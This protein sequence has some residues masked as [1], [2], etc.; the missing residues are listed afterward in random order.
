MRIVSISDTHNHHPSLQIPEGDVLVH[1][2]DATSRGTVQEIADFLAW[3]AGQPH[4]RK[5]LVA[6]NHDWGFQRETEAVRDLLAGHP[7]ITYLEDGG[8]RID[9]VRF[10]GSPWQP[11]FCDWAFNLPRGGDALREKW[12][13][14]PLDCQVLITH[15]P[16]QGVLDRTPDRYDRMGR[17]VGCEDLQARLAAVKPRIHI[18]GHIHCGYGVTVSGG[19]TYLNASVCDENYRPINRPIIADL[20]AARVTTS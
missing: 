20:E 9:G 3:F 10:W 14:I 15:G 18:F 8:T 2:G 11:W 19:T 17:H 7:G 6:G 12:S 1:A 4:A 16:P 13:R 5:I